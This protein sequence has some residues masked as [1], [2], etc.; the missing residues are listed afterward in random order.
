MKFNKLS[1]KHK[2]IFAKYLAL[3]YHELSPYSFENIYIWKGLFDIEWIEIEGNLCVFFKDK[4]SCFLYVSPLAKKIHQKAV[5]KVFEIMDRFNRNKEVSRIENVEIKDVPFYEKLGYRCQVKSNDY[6]CKAKDLVDLKGNKFKS[7]RSCFNYF[8]KRYKFEYRQFSLRDKSGCMKLYDAWAEERRSQNKDPI[9]Q[10]M[11]KD[12]RLCLINALGAYVNLGLIGRVVTI[13][14]HG[15]NKEVAGFTFG[16]KLNSDTFCILYE[17]TDLAIKGLAQFIFRRF[18]SEL[19]DYKYIN[20][21]DDSGLENLKK[22]KLSYYPV[23]LIP[24]YILIKSRE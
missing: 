8:I 18:C 23:R 1:L 19:K 16:F 3:D 20:I 22:V 13:E 24:A 14:G 17:V 2:A 6:L 21:M 9:Y 7:K 12:S 5:R 11:L 4:F 15:N 10:G